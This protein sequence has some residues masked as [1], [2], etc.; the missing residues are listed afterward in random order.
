[1]YGINKYFMDYLE[2]AATGSLDTPIASLPFPKAREVVLPET[3]TT[4]F[5]RYGWSC[6]HMCCG[7]CVSQMSKK[8][9]PLVDKLFRKYRPTRPVPS[10]GIVD[11]V[12]SVGETTDVIQACKRHGIKVNGFIT[13]AVAIATYKLL[14][15]YELIDSGKV[16]F[17]TAFMV[18]IRRFADPRIPE[19]HVGL[20][21]GFCDHRIKVKEANTDVATEP[22]WDLVKK[23]HSDVHKMVNS[24]RHFKLGRMRDSLYIKNGVEWAFDADNLKKREFFVIT[25]RGNFIVRGK[26]RENPSVTLEKTHWG[27]ADFMVGNNA[28]FTHSLCTLN[29]RLQWSLSYSKLMATKTFAR[30]YADMIKRTIIHAAQC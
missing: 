3:R 17:A 27:C 5:G 9:D 16:T 15:D 11:F 24:G 20:W 25:N 29:G 8:T 28:L 4:G 13:A 7:C 1:M 10:N 26:N 2:E 19:E 23:C 6:M 14:E 18:N 21:N 22:F 12:L 30:E